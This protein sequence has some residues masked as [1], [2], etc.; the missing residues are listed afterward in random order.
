MTR[1]RAVR[2]L[3]TLALALWVVAGCVARRTDSAPIA[4]PPFLLGSFTDDYGERYEITAT[5]WAQ[6]PKGRY[7]IVQWNVPGQYLIARNDSAN[8]GDPG[9]WTRIDWL[10]LAGM[11]PYT[12]A[13]CYSVYRAPSQA[14]AE[15]VSVARRD[16]PR[17][18]CNGFPFSRMRP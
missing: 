9:L 13:Y 2:R 15:T 18:G 10:P 16:T 11:P 12:W 3:S 8:A 14:V 7:H 17:T 4:P 6:L 5:M 1:P